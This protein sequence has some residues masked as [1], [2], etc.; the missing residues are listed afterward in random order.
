VAG[1][2]ERIAAN[3]ARARLE[4]EERGAWFDTHARVL[5]DCE[6]FDRDCH[7]HLSLSREEYEHVRAKPTT[8]AI[9]PGHLDTDMEYVSE[10]HDS[11]WVTEKATE[12]GQRVS[13]DLD[14]R[15]G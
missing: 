15:S 13:E 5:F 12:D 7:A 14:P 4:N 6:C 2:D 9:H 1:R 11:H 10:K 8:F 3:E